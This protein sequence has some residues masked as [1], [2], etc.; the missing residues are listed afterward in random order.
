MN[1]TIEMLDSAIERI[2]EL[3]PGAGKTIPLHAPVLGQLEKDY[4]AQCVDST[5]VSSVGAFVDRFEREVAAFCGARFA[6]A[7]VNGTAALHI[8]LLL[9][10]VGQGD[11]VLTQPLT[12]VA[13]CNAM[14]YCGA[15]PL[16]LDVSRQTLGLDP[17]AVEAYLAQDTRREGGRLVDAATGRRVAACLPMSTFGL[18]ADLPGLLAVCERYG[19]PV[20][21]D[22]AEALGSTREGRHMGTYGRLGTLSFNGNKAIT[23]GGGGM[24]LTDDEELARRA[25]HLTTT[26]KT[27]HAWEYAHDIVGYNYRLPNLN[28]A[29]GCAQMERLPELL[30]DK[31]LLAR[32]YAEAFGALGLPFVSEPEGCSS[33]YWLNALLLP[34][35]EVRDTMI[36]RAAKQGVHCR[37]AWRLMH[38]LPAFEGCPRRDLRVSEELAARLVNIPSSPRV[39]P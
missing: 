2:R 4:L 14:A 17:E 22:A 15:S 1:V 11:L 3:H 38:L 5:Y 12:F 18:P 7:T 34:D 30:A 19:I 25:K 35:A 13:T 16:F 32:Q 26:A 33:N 24:I 28:A 9:A 23:T 8:A 20:V 27:A 36:G 37:P 29:L 39:A 21:E 6:V 10:G 31:R